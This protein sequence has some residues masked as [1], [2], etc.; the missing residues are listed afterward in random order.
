MLWGEKWRFRERCR[1]GGVLLFVCTSGGLGD[2]VGSLFGSAAGGVVG[3]AFSGLGDS[4]LGHCLFSELL[5]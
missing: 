3:S 2:L 1:L 4:L 5:E